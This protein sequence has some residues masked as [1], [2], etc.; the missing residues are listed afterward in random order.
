L[1]REGNTSG[2]AVG[3]LIVLFVWGLF[4]RRDARSI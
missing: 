2:A 4:A 1:R 3:A